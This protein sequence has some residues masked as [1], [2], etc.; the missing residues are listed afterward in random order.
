MTIQ[1]GKEI[2]G[3]TTEIEVPTADDPPGNNRNLGAGQGPQGGGKRA[4]DIAVE[5]GMWRRA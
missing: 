3:D 2:G 4:R 5:A 1:I